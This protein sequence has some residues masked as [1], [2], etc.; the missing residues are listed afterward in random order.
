MRRSSTRDASDRVVTS[1]SRATVDKADDTQLMQEVT[2]RIYS[3]EAQ[4]T[5]EH[6]HPYGFS[7]V[8]MPRDDSNK[9]SG[10][11]S[12]EATAAES[13]VV[14]MNGDR[15]H[16]VAVVTGDRRFRLYKMKN[17]EVAM[18]DDQGQWAF[19]RR[20]GMLVKVPNG[21][22]VTL[23]VD[24][25]Q[26]AQQGKRVNG[27]DSTKIPKSVTSV[28]LDKSSIT[29]NAPQQISLTVGGSSVVLTPQNVTAIAQKV[30]TNPDNQGETYLNTQEKTSVV[31]LGLLDSPKVFVK[32]PGPLDPE[33]VALAEAAASASSAAGAAGA[34]AGEAQTVA[35]AASAEAA[36]ALLLAQG[37]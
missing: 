28:H 9:D 34:A 17:G 30:Q 1:G 35:D 36:Q 25:Q 16:G 21:N 7:A 32:I 31:G 10:N 22:D 15:S 8:P 27:Q 12:G 14:Y 11:A 2:H 23:Q 6:A 24:E 13:F 3:D 5:I 20:T 18:H 19:F 29:L 37:G 26:P 4:D 33:A